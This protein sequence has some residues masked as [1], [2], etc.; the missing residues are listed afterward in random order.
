MFDIAAVHEKFIAGH[1]GEASLHRGLLEIFSA[2]TGVCRT[3]T[4]SHGSVR[5]IEHADRAVTLQPLDVTNVRKLRVLPYHT[6]R[7][8]SFEKVAYRL[9]S[10][11][12][13]NLDFLCVKL[14]ALGLKELVED[15]TSLERTDAE[16]TSVSD[17]IQSLWRFQT[18]DERVEQLPQVLVTNL[19]TLS[20]KHH[21][22][23][24]LL[25]QAKM[26]CMKAR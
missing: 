17:V 18:H 19:E 8:G 7:S 1:V 24:N 11:V 20:E 12:L 3:L 21:G 4:L 9:K 26:A 23:K 16:L 13:F 2:D 10:R 14:R 5:R 25:A 15:F 6:Q 22:L